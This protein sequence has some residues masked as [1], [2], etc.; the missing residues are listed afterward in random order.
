MVSAVYRKSGSEF[1]EGTK[2]LRRFLSPH[3]TALRMVISSR[4]GRPIAFIVKLKLLIIAGYA[5]TSVPSKSKIISLAPD[6]F[7]ASWLQIKRAGIL[8]LPSYV[9]DQTVIVFL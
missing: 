5:S 6:I 1:L 3:P 9:Y 2:G 8:S 7:I 4:K